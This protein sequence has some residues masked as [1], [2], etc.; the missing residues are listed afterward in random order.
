MTAT[1]A[2]DEEVS[3]LEDSEDKDVTDAAAGVRG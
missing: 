1:P 2:K 3:P